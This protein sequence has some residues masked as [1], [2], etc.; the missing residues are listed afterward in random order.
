MENIS[1][2]TVSCMMTHLDIKMHENMDYRARNR[3][4]KLILMICL[5]HFPNRLHK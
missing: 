5:L 4:E 3:Y 1:P 2:L